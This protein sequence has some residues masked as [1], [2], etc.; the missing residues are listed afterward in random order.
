MENLNPNSLLPKK[1]SKNKSWLWAGLILV[2]L[3]LGATFF[4]LF[5]SENEQ[6]DQQ[7]EISFER[8][9]VNQDKLPDGLPVD[10]P[11]ETGS[12]I[13]QNEIITSSSFDGTQY[14]RR[15]VSE[16]NL[17]ESFK[18]YKQYMENGGW[19]ILSS[20]DEADLKFL[21]GQKE[22]TSEQL[23]ITISKNE[24]SGQVTVDLT[25]VTK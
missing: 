10:I 20:V 5:N 16:K 17:D 13:L 24:I 3:V 11:L 14:V 18:T 2:I 19:E 6:S 7:A 25:V 23:F 8:K 22:S 15:F 9:Q 1:S 4:L 21:S 12:Q